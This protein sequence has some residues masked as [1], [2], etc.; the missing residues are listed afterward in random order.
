MAAQTAVLNLGQEGMALAYSL[1]RMHRREDPYAF[2]AGIFR[3]KRWESAEFADIK[4][5]YLPSLIVK[6]FRE[7]QRT[8]G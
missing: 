7:G 3:P 5:R 4:W 6:L 1:D 8:L 2:H